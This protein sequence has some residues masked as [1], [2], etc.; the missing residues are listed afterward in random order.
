M[1]V[2]AFLN[3]RFSTTHENQIFDELLKRLKERWNDSDESVILLGN[4]FYNNRD[5]DATL[6][7][8]DAI[9]VVDFKDYGG[10]LRFSENSIWKIGDINVK[11][12]AFVN[13]FMQVRSSKSLISNFFKENTENIFKTANKKIAFNDIYGLIL[14]HRH[15]ELLN[16]LP[17][18]VKKWFYI[19]DI[20]NICQ[21]FHQITNSNL[22]LSDDEIQRIPSLLGLQ[23]YQLFQSK[24]IAL[25][26]VKEK[27][28]GGNGL[29]ELLFSLLTLKEELEAKDILKNKFDIFRKKH[30]RLISHFQFAATERLL[31]G[32]L[33]KVQQFDKEISEF[34]IH[35]EN[36]ILSKIESVLN[37]N[38]NANLILDELSNLKVTKEQLGNVKNVNSL[39]NRLQK[40][41]IS[42]IEF[43]KI[44]LTKLKAIELF[45]YNRGIFSNSFL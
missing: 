12:G 14:F 39:I 23:E 21:T 3:S 43:S 33:T 31:I 19:S 4:F 15:I 30:E 28:N 10:Q 32:N 25:E 18:E 20:D 24:G 29:D 44:N 37:C 2:K 1:Q 8:R 5:I 36:E 16:P 45:T 6:I 22:N 42:K 35:I 41:T 27:N 7:K 40:K 26:R 38:A 17:G 11:G 34:K 9:I 13:P